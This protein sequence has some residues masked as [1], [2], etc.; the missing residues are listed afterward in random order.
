MKTLMSA[1]LAGASVFALASFAPV[2]NAQA[3]EAA[4]KGESN[5]LGEV[6]VTAR[7]QAE[8]LQ[9]VPQTVV[10]LTAE[11]LQSLEI[12][13]IQDIQT[14]VPGLQLGTTNGSLVTLRGISFNNFTNGD[15]TVA[16]YL[17]DTNY[18]PGLVANATFDLGQIEVLRGPQGT[19]RGVSAPSGA[20]TVTTRRP[21]MSEIG[22]YLDGT[23]ANHSTRVLEGAI[24]APIIKDVLAVRLAGVYT[25]DDNGGTRSVN[26]PTKPVRD[27][28]TTRLSLRFTPSDDFEGNVMWQHGEN[29]K[30]RGG[31]AV[32]GAGN[33]RPTNPALGRTQNL[34]VT[35]ALSES[36]GKNDY[37]TA[38]M[39]YTALGHH[40][41]YVGS[42][43]HAY[44]PTS[45]PNDTPNALPGVESFT[46]TH[47][48]VET[49]T[50]EF[51]V[52]SEPKEGRFLDYTAG[53]YYSWYDQGGNSHF[54]PT[55]LP[56]AFGG[57]LA[58]PNTALFNPRYAV[59]GFVLL[60]TIYQ[61]TAIF[62]SLTA[63]ITPNTELTVG[64]RHIASIFKGNATVTT[65]AGVI[66]LA[67]PTG[68]FLSCSALA[69]LS[70]ALR[71]ATTSAYPGLCDLPIAPRRV[72]DVSS[73]TSE[74][75][76]IYTVSLTHRFTP[77]FMMYANTGT[78]FL[79]PT[80]TI[81]LQGPFASSSDPKVRALA[82]HPSQDSTSY[83]AGFKW[84][85]LEGRGRLNAAVY[86]QTF[87]DFQIQV[88]GI[89][90]LDNTITPASRGTFNFPTGVSAKVTGFDADATF[91]VTPELDVSI[92]AS[93]SS[94]KAT[95]PVPCNINDAAGQ[96]VF[97][98]GGI[99][100]FCP[101]GGL[102][103]NTPKWNASMNT[104]YR[105]QI[106]DDLDGFLRG[107]FQFYPKNTQAGTTYSA[108]S[109]ALVN[110]FAGVSSKS[111]GWEATAYVKNLFNDQTLL[112]RSEQ[113]LAPGGLG[114]FPTLNART[115]YFTYS[116]PPRREL[117]VSLRYAFGSH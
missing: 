49:T 13:K 71:G 103:A 68:G 8:N 15:S 39:D 72:S 10:P 92:L 57:N 20:I 82:F 42:Y 61:E 84:T 56:G 67:N 75:P 70:P 19:T 117:G 94:G 12:R 87:K 74:R 7:R 22:G 17:N 58:V 99:I 28:Y 21:N 90:Y 11:K 105:H 93:Y 23:L 29:F 9:D 114:S 30:T 101:G 66:A 85:F 79:R 46:T 32:Y 24:G 65:T 41:S 69:A 102:V 35:D 62:G 106:S 60:P 3:A 37:V 2:E 16:F 6:I 108:P 45:A 83:E 112:R 40:F 97:N 107:L 104:D 86:H 100:S 78:S 43:S 50:Q 110:L 96:P 33:G 5:T 95:G 51:R 34:G 115:T 113:A 80:A 38:Q 36:K 27:G 26:S 63:H 73:R 4:A 18:G 116:I 98:T 77:D 44:G 59:D 14:I 55:Y 89:Q 88:S 91:R 111:G 109:Y 53:V 47:I 52:S 81:G 48:F 76:T 1:A 25:H 54:S 64:A 31:T